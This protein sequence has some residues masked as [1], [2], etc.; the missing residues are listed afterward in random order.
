MKT[1]S[2]RSVR[3]KNFRRKRKSISFLRRLLVCFSFFMTLWML[4]NDFSWNLEENQRLYTR[5]ETTNSER[6]IY[7]QRQDAWWSTWRKHERENVLMAASN[8]TRWNLYVETVK[9]NQQKNTRLNL[10][11]NSISNLNP[12]SQAWTAAK[13]TF[14]CCENLISSLALSASRVVLSLLPLHFALL[15]VFSHGLRARAI[16]SRKTN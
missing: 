9:L 15:V 10:E 13:W 1:L 11:I 2:L 12:L 7:W 4:K 5:V 14:S 8:S 16:L 6:A 3:L